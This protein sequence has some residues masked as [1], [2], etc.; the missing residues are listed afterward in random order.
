MRN[1]GILHNIVK[2][3]VPMRRSARLVTTSVQREVFEAKNDHRMPVPVDSRSS[4][5]N[6]S[7]ATLQRKDEKITSDDWISLCSTRELSCALT[8]ESGQVFAWQKHPSQSA[9][10]M[11]VIG[12]RLYA[13]RE[14]SHFVQFQC[15]HPADLSTSESIKELSHYFRLDVDADQ[16]YER[17]TTENDRMTKIIKRLRGLR[18]IRQDPVECLFSFICSSNNNIARIQGM[19]DKLKATYGELIYRADVDDNQRVFYAF[20]S[21]DTLADKCEETTLRAL[22]FGYRAPFIVKTAKQLKELGGASYLCNIC[23]NKAAP[24]DK[25]KKRKVP[26]NTGDPLNQTEAYC[27][28]QEKLMVFAGVGRKVADCVALFSLDRMEAIPVDTHVWQIACR[29][30]DPTLSDRKSITPTVYHMVGDLFRKRF[31]P[32]AGWAHSVLFTGDLSTFQSQVFDQETKPSIKRK[33]IIHSSSTSSSKRKT[34]IP[35]ASVS[36]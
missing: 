14:R 16:L 4:A 33:S 7:S 35:R 30:L 5:P 3:V 36:H 11:G 22:G 25:N 9:T 18:I 2:I 31:A 24:L 32:Q 13:L 34:D 27:A 6:C 17:W 28:Y 29:E 1:A 19:V 8:L 26:V 10:W 23:D 20:P 21:L 12:R 15:L